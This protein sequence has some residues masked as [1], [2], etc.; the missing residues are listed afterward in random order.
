A[1]TTIRLRVPTGWWSCGPC[2][3]PAR[4]PPWQSRG[5]SCWRSVA[6]DVRS[7]APPVEVANEP[8][9][10]DAGACVDHGRASR[11]AVPGAH[12]RDGFLLVADRRAAH[13]L[14]GGL[15]APFA[16]LR[17]AASARPALARGHVVDHP[18]RHHHDRVLLGRPSLRGAGGAARRRARSL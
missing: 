9:L 13:P 4:S 14:H 7:M 1:I 15:P 16:R 5:S 10:A 2:A 8:L 18:A 3:W 6:N 11:R 17:P 12:R